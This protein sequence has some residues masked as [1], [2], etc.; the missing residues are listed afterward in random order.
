MSGSSPHTR[1]ANLGAHTL[2][3]FQMWEPRL[4]TSEWFEFARTSYLQH[5]SPKSGTKPLAPCRNQKNANSKTRTAI[6]RRFSPPATPAV[7]AIYQ[8]RASCLRLTS[9]KSRALDNTCFQRN[10]LF[11]RPQLP[12]SITSAARNFHV[13]NFMKIFIFFA[14]LSIVYIQKQPTKKHIIVSRGT[15]SQNVSRPAISN[16]PRRTPYS[17]HPATSV[18]SQTFTIIWP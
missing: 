11:S 10:F 17:I 12:D 9:L 13:K 5:F 18:P 2:A 16:V 3:L 6:F 4:P 8:H 15:F 14:L 1:E 7:S